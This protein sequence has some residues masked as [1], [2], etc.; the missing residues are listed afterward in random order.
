MTMIAVSDDNNTRTPLDL[1]NATHCK[2]KLAVN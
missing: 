2:R 1:I